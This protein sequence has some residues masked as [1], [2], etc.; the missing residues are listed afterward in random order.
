MKRKITALCLVVALLAVAVVG[1]TMAYFTDTDEATNV[2]TIGNIKI[3]LL[4]D[5]MDPADYNQILSGKT[6]VPGQEISK[7]V[8]VKNI[9][10]KDDAYVRVKITVPSKLIP[11]WADNYT[12]DWDVISSTKEGENTVYVL[13]YKKVLE[14]GQETSACLA[15]IMMDKYS[16]QAD[17]T[18][19]TLNV[20]VYVEAIQAVGFNK[21]TE[22]FAA[23]DAQL[24]VNDPNVDVVTVSDSKSLYDEIAKGNAVILSDDF[25]FVSD[26][27]NGYGATGLSQKNGGVI[28][29]NGKTLTVEG[30]TGTW[31]SA[32]NT[33]GGMIKNLTINSG[34]RGIF[35]TAGTERVLVDNVT[36]DGTTYTIHCD[37]AS[38]Q[39]LTVTNSTLN[40]WT[41]YAGTLGDALFI[42]CN[43]GESSG[44]A[45]MRPY[46][47]TVMK[48]CHF[49]A[50]FQMDPRASVVLENCYLDGVL[51][52][53]DNLSTL[54]PSN[55]ANA[56]VK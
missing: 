40:G 51:I 32:I 45:Y 15:K 29:G 14:A 18:G 21:S 44:Y 55:I 10:D 23:L 54:V 24:I 46:A 16:T 41:S 34:F 11:V 17:F 35:I 36:I 30:A 28:D 42:D 43:F 7:E 52:T 2:F 39:G 47:P 6:I 27:S 19:S 31:D 50:G 20:P 22:A 38:G 53:A 33:S 9:S 5:G 1:G 56:T 26:A 8:T 49:A 3:E 13:G 25:T 37:S 4:E 48:N 12:T